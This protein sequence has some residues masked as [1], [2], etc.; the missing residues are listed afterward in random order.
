MDAHTPHTTTPGKPGGALPV[1]AAPVRAN[2]HYERLGGADVVARLAEAFY[3]AMDELPEATTIRA[4]HEA[5]LGAT[6][7]VLQSYLSEWLGGPKL[8]SPIRGVPKLRRVHQPFAIDA[9][10]R[11]AWMA[12]MRRAL[13]EVCVD[14]AL[15]AELDTAFYKI[16]DFI[17]N[18][19]TTPSTVPHP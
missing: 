13:A 16:A 12:C 19:A 17:R 1:L 6:Q 18:T 11:D 2:P 14:E 7:A 8:Y 3:R 9:S 10:A 5:D 15:R 4:M